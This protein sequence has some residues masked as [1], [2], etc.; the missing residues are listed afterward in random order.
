MQPRLIVPIVS[1]QSKKA[2]C[3]FQALLSA[4]AMG[5]LKYGLVCLILA[6]CTQVTPAPCPDYCR[7]KSK[8]HCLCDSGYTV[9]GGKREIGELVTLTTNRPF[10]K[11]ENQCETLIG[12]VRDLVKTDQFGKKSQSIFK[13]LLNMYLRFGLR[14]CKVR[15]KRSRANIDGNDLLHK[16]AISDK[17]N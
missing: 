17:N 1:S 5:K 13:K 15:R 16:T 12:I 14:R 6:F 8:T 10:A 4:S 7:V 3:I 9:L 11:R 2:I